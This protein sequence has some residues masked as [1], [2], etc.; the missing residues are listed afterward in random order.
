MPTMQPHHD[1]Q[2]QLNELFAAYRQ[3]MTDLDGGPD[4]LPGLWGK[5]ESRRV[6]TSVWLAWTRAILS[7]AC[8]AVVLLVSVGLWAPLE[9]STYYDASYVEALDASEDV[10]VMAALHPASPVEPPT[11]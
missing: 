6:Q 4:F 7:G 5:I 1:R 10:V 11:E 9:R 3:E 2:D 8:V